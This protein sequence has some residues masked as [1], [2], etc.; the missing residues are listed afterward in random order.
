V[1]RQFFQIIFGKLCS[2]VRKDTGGR[3]QINLEFTMDFAV[4][5]IPEPVAQHGSNHQPCAMSR[6]M[7][8]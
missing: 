4:P 3:S 5:F 6:L 7:R 2:I 1:T 8:G